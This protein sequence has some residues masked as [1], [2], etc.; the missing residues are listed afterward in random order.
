MGSIIFSSHHDIRIAGRKADM[1]HP[2][3]MVILFIGYICFLL[4]WK[5]V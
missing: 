3:M 2:R 5:G 1:T 4:P